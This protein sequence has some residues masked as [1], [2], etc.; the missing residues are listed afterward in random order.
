MRRRRVVPVIVF[1]VLAL[2]LVPLP[3]CAS[4]NRISTTQIMVQVGG[5]ELLHL[6][7]VPRELPDGR[8]SSAQTTELL[9]AVAKRAGGYTYIENVKGGWLPPGK[10]E[11]VKEDN[12]LLLVKGAPQLADFLK[13]RLRDEF[14][15]T[16]PFVVSLPI[17]SVKILEGSGQGLIEVKSRN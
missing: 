6:A 4:L 14:E 1:C 9:Q 5:E 10:D 2:L 17:Q 8:R 11:V 12:D 16:H 7:V 13:D 3:G 15:Q